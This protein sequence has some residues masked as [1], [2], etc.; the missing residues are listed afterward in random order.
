MFLS[1]LSFYNVHRDGI[2]FWSFVATLKKL[3]LSQRS[4]L[5]QEYEQKIK[6][7]YFLEPKES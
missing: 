5:T 6:I 7:C 4:Q 1:G 3:V 2:K